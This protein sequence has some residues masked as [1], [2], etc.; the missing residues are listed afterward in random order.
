MM[1][2]GGQEPQ[3]SSFHFLRLKGIRCLLKDKIKE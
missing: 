2:Y 3:G 1:N